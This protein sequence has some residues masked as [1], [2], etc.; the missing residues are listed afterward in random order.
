MHLIESYATNCG[1]KIDEPFIYEKF[2]PLAFDKYITFSPASN[3]AQ[4]YDYWVEVINIIHP[5]LKKEG[6]KPQT[7]VP[8]KLVGDPVWRPI[9]ESAWE[10]NGQA[11]L[12]DNNI[13]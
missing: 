7:V 1:L 6:I 12:G 13:W 4:D 5:K 3:P 2:F 11:N 8:N 10:G 9:E